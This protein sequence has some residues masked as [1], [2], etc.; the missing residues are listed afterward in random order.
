M[1]M[2]MLLV[3]DGAGMVSVVPL[4][5]FDFPVAAGIFIFSRATMDLVP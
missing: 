4:Y 1:L 3:L 2:L 5:I